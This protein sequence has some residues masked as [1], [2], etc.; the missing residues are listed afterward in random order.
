MKDEGRKVIVHDNQ[1]RE[2]KLAELAH[3]P[4]GDYFLQVNS[5]AKA[6][7][8]ASINRQWRG[9]FEEEVTKARNAL[10]TKRGTKNYDKVI[11]RVGR[12]R[13][14]YPSVA[15]YYQIEY[16]RSAEK[17]Q[18]MGDIRWSINISPEQAE[19]RCGTY[20]LR[21]NVQ[22][23]GERTTW[24]YYN[25]IRE[26]ETINRQ[27]KTDLELRPIYHRKDD[28]SDAHLFFGLLAYWVVNTIRHQ[29]KQNGIK[30]YWNE[31][32][33]RMSTQKLVTT[34]GINPLG[35][36][37]ELRQC[38][39]PKKSARQIYQ[40]LGYREAPFKKIK[41]VGHTSPRLN[42][43]LAEQQQKRNLTSETWVKTLISTE[44]RFR[45]K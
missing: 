21:T 18:N 36:K 10:I 43:Q 8:E 41:F 30:C 25:L 20:F 6:L 27:L 2:I 12:A 45:P 35:D 28:R 11:E 19:Q 17:P 14:K 38:S 5:P 26:I 42:N 33:R 34:A 4:G 31:I 22:T 3:E 37:V 24:D 23:L 1:G 44:E 39:Q 15:K 16:I 32:V 13:G 9:R 40:A 7:T 29:L